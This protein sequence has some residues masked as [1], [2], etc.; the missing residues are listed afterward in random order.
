MLRRRRWRRGA[1]TGIL[2][3]ASRSRARPGRPGSDSR[4]QVTPPAS[5]RT[6][7]QSSSSA[8]ALPGAG[9]RRQ[10]GRISCPRSFETVVGC[11]C[12]LPPV[13]CRQLHCSK[14]KTGPPDAAVVRIKYITKC[15]TAYLH[16]G[17]SNCLFLV[18]RD[19][20]FVHGTRSC[21]HMEL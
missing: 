19:K 8:S 17:F 7:L 10:R 5:I 6:P 21:G 12:A 3:R 11:R 2:S 20:N 9:S 4:G 13:L 1:G 15:E 16:C 18:Q 14:N